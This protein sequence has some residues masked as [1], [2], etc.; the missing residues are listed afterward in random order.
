MIFF[1]KLKFLCSKTFGKVAQVAKIVNL[2]KLLG[3]KF[4]LG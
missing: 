1:E 3:Q 4:F 2:G